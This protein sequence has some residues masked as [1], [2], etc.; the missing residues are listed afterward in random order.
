MFSDSCAYTRE[1]GFYVL[2][3]KYVSRVPGEVD[4]SMI[5]G[6]ASAEGCDEGSSETEKE[7][8]IDVILDHRL[9]ATSF[10]KKSYGTYMKQYVKKIFQLLEASGKTKEEID[11]LKADTK[12]SF[13][14][15]L[16]NFKEYEF[17][18][19][20]SANDEGLVALLEWKDVEVNG[21]QVSTPFV[22]FY[23]AGLLEE[24][25]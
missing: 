17:F 3:G 19:G 11:A 21:E 15:V 4:D 16:A 8:G 18:I 25:Y 20:E 5:G 23:V 12:A 9:M 2:K 1:G 7:H 10:D 6:N 13:Q 24:K 22:Y 14:A